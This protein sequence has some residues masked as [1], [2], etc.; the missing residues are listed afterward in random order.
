MWICIVRPTLYTS[1]F[2]L[3]IY[4][5]LNRVA[6]PDI[7]VDKGILA[8]ISHS[9]PH[10]SWSADFSVIQQGPAPP[11]CSLIV[12]SLKKKSKPKK[13][14]YNNTVWVVSSILDLNE[15]RRRVFVVA[16]V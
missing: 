6:F 2:D 15:S 3:F 4:C 8:V 12:N 14:E 9:P 13:Q 1:P 16:K 10:Y 7:L 11:P 5:E